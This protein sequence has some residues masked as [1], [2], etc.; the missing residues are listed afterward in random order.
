MKMSAEKK[1]E[2]VP[3]IFEYISYGELIRLIICL[4]ID[5]IEYFI[6]ILLTPLVG[7]IYDIIGLATSFY[8]FGWIGLFSA[9][10]LIPG[11]DILPINTITWLIWLI[12]KRSKASQKRV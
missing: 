7:D 9:L 11:L 2:K 5:G 4:V 1:T 10:D 6:P 12:N 8:M 3:S